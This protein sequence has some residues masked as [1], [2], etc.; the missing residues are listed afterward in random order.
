[1]MIAESSGKEG[2]VPMRFEVLHDDREDWGY[3]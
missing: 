2:D 3:V 1:M